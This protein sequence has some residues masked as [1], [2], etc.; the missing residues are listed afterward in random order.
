MQTQSFEIPLSHTG[1][2]VKKR[3]EICVAE[4]IPVL[5]TGGTGLGK[6][7]FLSRLARQHN[8]HLTKINQVGSSADMVLGMLVAT[9]FTTRWQDGLLTDKVRHGGWLSVEEIARLDQEI[10]GR[11]FSLLDTDDPVLSLVEMGENLTPHPDFRF[12]AT[13]NEGSE[14]FVRGI[15]KALRDRFFVQEWGLDFWNLDVLDDQVGVGKSNGNKLRQMLSQGVV[16]LRK[17]V[18]AIHLIQKGLEPRQAWTI[19]GINAAME[20]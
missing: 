4:Q 11:M 7:Y 8:Q 5:L 13:T 20:A 1:E 16:T 15:D 19:C 9:N 14:Y 18:I 12:F 17:V 10:Q 6:T 3:I 2:E